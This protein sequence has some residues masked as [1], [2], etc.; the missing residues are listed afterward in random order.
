MTAPPL[1]QNH[2]IS[3]AAAV[4]EKG[5][6]GRSIN[7]RSTATQQYEQDNIQPNFSISISSMIMKNPMNRFV[8]EHEDK[9]S[10]TE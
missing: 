4:A 6:R 2:Q 9:R 5:V 1:A 7:N 8:F 3:S 10:E